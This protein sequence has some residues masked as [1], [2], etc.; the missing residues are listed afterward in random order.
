M[1]GIQQDNILSTQVIGRQYGLAN[2]VSLTSG[3]GL[4]E[5]SVSW[6]ARNASVDALQVWQ[7]LDIATGL[8]FSDLAAANDGALTPQ[9]VVNQ[10]ASDRL[11]VKAGDVL[12]MGWFITEEGQR[13]KRQADVQVHAV[14]ANEG[15]GRDGGHTSL[16]QYS[17]TCP[18]HKRLLEAPGDHQSDV[19]RVG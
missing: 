18:Q 6:F 9:V 7:P 13:V 3:E 14:V 12:E 11:E 2:G 16:Q 19:P 8:R 17:P 1:E 5:P 15:Q 4:A 10:V